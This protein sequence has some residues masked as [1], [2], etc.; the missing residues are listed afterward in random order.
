MLSRNT[1]VLMAVLVL[2][3]SALLADE[4]SVPEAI[5]LEVGAPLP[6]LEG[7]DDAGA[8]WKSADYVG[9]KVLVLY[10][11]PGDFT[12]GCTRQVQAFRDGL[13]RLEEEGAIVVGI[14]G[15]LPATHKLFKDAYA[16]NHTLLSDSDG[17]LACTLGVPV[18]DGGKA[19]VRQADG[20]VPLDDR[21]KSMIIERP[22]TLARWTY[23]VG[24]DGTIASV[25]RNV[26]P[27]TDP[28]EVLAIVREL[29]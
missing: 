3:S 7:I 20:T 12:T 19:R 5:S 29:R 25:R 23:V 22:I 10:F 16:L 21:R 26:N 6:E 4:G 8:K 17:N 11:Y 15:D 14:S 27:A 9:K 1:L 24:R 2:G 13:A 28:D 18:S